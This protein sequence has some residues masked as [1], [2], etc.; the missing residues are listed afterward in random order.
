MTNRAFIIIII[1][2][3]IAMLSVLALKSNDSKLEEKVSNN[4]EEFSEEIAK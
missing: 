2:L 3:F 4:L 1:V